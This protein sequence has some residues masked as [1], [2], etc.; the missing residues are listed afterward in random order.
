MAG[1][2]MFETRSSVFPSNE[3]LKRCPVDLLKYFT[4]SSPGTSVPPTAGSDE[5]RKRR[6][7][8]EDSGFEDPVLVP[9]EAPP[10]SPQVFPPV[11]NVPTCPSGVG[12]APL[13]K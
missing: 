7:S 3:F 9:P 5:I 10:C 1:I 13:I 8:G 4:R 11:G 2:V 12:S 6:L